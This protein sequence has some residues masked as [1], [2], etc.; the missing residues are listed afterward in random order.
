MFV[1]IR[2][3]KV[4]AGNGSVLHIEKDDDG[5]DSDVED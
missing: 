5:E 1:Y 2:D 4:D 3:V